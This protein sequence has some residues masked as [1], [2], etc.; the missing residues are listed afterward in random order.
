MP[1]NPSC[2]TCRFWDETNIGEPDFGV[3]RKHA[4]REVRKP[5]ERSL[6]TCLAAYWPMTRRLEWCGEWEAKECLCGA[7]RSI[8]PV[9]TLERIHNPK[10]PVHGGEVN[11]Q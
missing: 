7:K 10:C 11:K 8:G 6:I 3:C 9:K 2:K 4:P 5:L 1:E